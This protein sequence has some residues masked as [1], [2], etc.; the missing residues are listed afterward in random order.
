MTDGVS[1]NVAEQAGSPVAGAAT[2]QLAKGAFGWRSLA[3]LGVSFTAAGYFAPWSFGLDSAGWAGMLA[4]FLLVGLFYFCLLQCLAEMSA[5]IPSSGGGQAFAAEAFGPV[6]GF[7]AGAAALVQWVCSAAALAVLLG[8]YVQ[9]LTG[10]SAT[11]ITLTAYGLFIAILLTGA[12]EAVALTLVCSL[13]ALAGAVLFVWYTGQ[14]ASAEIFRA[15]D[16]ATIPLGGLWLALP[17]GVTFFLGL[18]GVP[19]AAEEAVD[20][21]RDVPKGLRLALLTVALLGLAVLVFGPAGAG[22]AALKGSSEPILAGLAA[23]G[24]AAPHMLLGATNVAAVAGLGT[25][26]FGSIY[27]YSRLVFAMARQHELPVGLARLNRRHAPVWGLIVPSLV[28][29]ALAL[30]GAIDQ[31]IIVMVFCAC[32]SYGMMFAAFIGLRKRCPALPRPY[33][34]RRAGLVVAGGILLG[35]VIFSSCI[36]VDPSWSALGGGMLAALLLYRLA[37]D[38]IAAAR[39]KDA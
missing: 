13:L 23:P 11:T 24:V 28:S 25:S 18:E 20:P 16:P 21:A 3:L 31:L 4:A 29:G 33:R 35:C 26:L 34:V 30:G 32:I 12:G 36:M 5:A 22:L 10:I 38:R 1:A 37:R 7:A 6:A 17:F 15:I 14:G 8:I 19:L 2:Q 27:A 39:R 9:S